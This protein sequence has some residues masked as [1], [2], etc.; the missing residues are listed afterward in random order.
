MIDRLRAVA[1]R[2]RPLQYVAAAIAVFLL[3]VVAF[4]VLSPPSPVGDKYLIPSLVG[5]LWSVSA[6][7]FIFIFRSIPERGNETERRWSRVKGM[8]WRGWYW[9]VALLFAAT[10]LAVVSASSK[11]LSVW[12]QDYAG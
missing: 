7:N 12:Y 11:L 6:Y 9:F 10:T 4:F 1:L 8:L 3:G 2:I 5:L